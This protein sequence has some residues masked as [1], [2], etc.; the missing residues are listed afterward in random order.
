MEENIEITLL[1]DIYGTL[2]TPKQQAIFQEYYLYNLSLREI[3]ENKNISYQAVRD[4]I[5]TSKHMLENFEKN[6]NM[7]YLQKK[8]DKVL[9]LCENSKDL[10][11]E[12]EQIIVLLK[13]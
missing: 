13:K 2:L 8:V 7:H 1:F 10:N 9:K 3:A 12:K 11:K 4:S 6:I 5:K